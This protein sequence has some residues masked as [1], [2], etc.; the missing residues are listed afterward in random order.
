VR[1]EPEVGKGVASRLG[2]RRG[3]RVPSPPEAFKNVNFEF[4]ERECL[5]LTVFEG[6]VVDCD[7]F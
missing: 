4:R 2:T 7:D 6:H 5:L 3:R 1:E